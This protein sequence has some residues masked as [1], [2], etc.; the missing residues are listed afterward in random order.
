MNKV[1]VKKS[2]NPPD[3]FFSTKLCL[4]SSSNKKFSKVVFFW[5]R[6]EA[7][8]LRERY[9]QKYHGGVGGV[10]KALQ[11]VTQQVCLIQDRFKTKI[12]AKIT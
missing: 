10:S 1:Q 5:C 6:A 7:K 3:I 8:E 9:M 12:F 11:P 2:K 4:N